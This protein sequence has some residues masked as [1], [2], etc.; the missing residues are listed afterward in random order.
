[1]KRSQLA[2]GAA[3]LATVAAGNAHAALIGVTQTFP[4]VTLTAS[5]YL[6]YDHNGVN[7]STGR[8]TVVTGAAQLA[9]G[10]AAGGS[11]VTQSYFGAGDSIPDFVFN[12]DVN[13]TTGAFIG[14]TVSIG[15]GNAPSSARFLWQGTVTDFGFISPG[16]SGNIFDAT[17][18][19]SDDQYQNM[20]VG[21]SQ[22][23][24][25]Y[26]T[27]GL[28]GLKI[29]SSAA[30]GTAANFGTDWIYGAGATTNPYLTAYTGGLTSPLRTNSTILAD[31]F[32]APAPV[33]LP[34]AVWLLV[35]GF[36]LIAPL[37]RRKSANRIAP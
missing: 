36:G 19:V 9:E 25:G 8:L 2:L 10:A 4:D 16:G 5:P 15:F 18:N 27:G 37:V 22:F 20:P 3:V 33:P 14:G 7:S 35:S 24:N 12:I 26:L 13:N 34:A 29:S 6:I 30:W 1:M 11:T 32:A 28:G 17:W 21:L 31:V 23:V